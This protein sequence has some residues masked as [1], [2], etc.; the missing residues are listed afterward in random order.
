MLPVSGAEQLKASG[1]TCERPMISHSG[2]YSRL[3]RPAP[4]FDSGRNRFHRPAALAWALSCSITLVGCQ[5]LP[6]LRFSAT[7]WWYTAS[8]G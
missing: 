6:A 1:A 8:A 5:G 4:Y 3:V 2:A 7:S